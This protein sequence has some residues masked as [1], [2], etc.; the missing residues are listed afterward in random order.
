MSTPK[1]ASGSPC[2]L[3]LK[4]GSGNL[5]HLHGGSPVRSASPR[6]KTPT[7]SPKTFFNTV[8]DPLYNILLNLPKEELQVICRVN[9]KAKKICKNTRFQKDWILAHLDP[10]IHKIGTKKVEYWNPLIYRTHGIT[11][12]G[13]ESERWQIRGLVDGKPKP[14]FITREVADRYISAGYPVT[15]VTLGNAKK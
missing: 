13:K 10:Y 1:T 11:A 7:R 15:T 14:V 4:K 2:K 9:E 8:G 3:C 6:S 12:A 5:C